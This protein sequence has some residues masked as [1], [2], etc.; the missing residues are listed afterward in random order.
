MLGETRLLSEYIAQRYPGATYHL[1]FPV[2]SD[3]DA[4]QGMI[5]DEGERRLMRNLN[6]RVDALVITETE[7]VVIEATM[8]RPTDKIGRLQE[9]RLLFPASPEFAELGNRRV[10]YELVTAQHDAVA[11]HLAAQLGFRYVYWEP[12][13]MDEFLAAY[14]ARRRRALHS[15]MVDI[16]AEQVR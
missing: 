2:G 12:T 15:G 3:P 5:L 9:Y 7:A 8:Y 16:L 10:V 1:Q 13:W 11:E 6:R 14:P 4:V